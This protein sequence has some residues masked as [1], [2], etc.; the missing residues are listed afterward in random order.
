MGLELPREMPEAGLVVGWDWNCDGMPEEFRNLPIM[1]LKGGAGA[2]KT[3]VARTFA[4]NCQDRG[5]ITASYFFSGMNSSQSKDP[6]R[7]ETNR[8]VGTLA[9]QIAREDPGTR[10]HIEAIIHQDPHI[11]DQDLRKQI[12]SLIL[13]PIRRSTRVSGAK[14][15]QRR[16][17]II[18]DGL[19]E[20]TGSEAQAAIVRAIA[21]AINTVSA[22]SHATLP[23]FLICSRP[24]ESIERVFRSPDLKGIYKKIDLGSAKTA[25]IDI[26]TFLRAKF[27]EIKRTHRRTDLIPKSWPS[28]TSLFALLHNSSG[29]FIYGETALKYISNHVR[30]VTALEVVLGQDTSMER[31]CQPFSELDTLYRHILSRALEKSSVE[32]IWRALGLVAMRSSP[33]GAFHPDITSKFLNLADGE[34]DTLLIA[35]SSLV[36]VSQFPSGITFYHKSFVDFLREK[37]RAGQF[38]IDEEAYLT[39]AWSRCVDVISKATTADVGG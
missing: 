26:N 29:H 2:G 33:A 25:T 10:A 31:S 27:D 12:V 16:C 6:S 39:Y 32:M 20:C 1:W 19:D 34:L 13:N 7:S 5:H 9:Y 24:E 18:I 11:F 22:D 23:R 37:S 38:Y 17:V 4:E 28:D 8:V 35:T 14:A 3:A 36:S 15:Q 30:P 21:E